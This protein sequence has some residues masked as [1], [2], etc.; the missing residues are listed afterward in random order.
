MNQRADFILVQN[1]AINGEK[2]SNSELQNTVIVIN[3]KCI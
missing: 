2:A 3:T 1:V